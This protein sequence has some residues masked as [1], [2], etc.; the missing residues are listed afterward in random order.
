MAAGA[1]STGTAVAALRE[2][3]MPQRIG[4]GCGRLVA[5]LSASAFLAAA[6]VAATPVWRMA[7]AW[8]ACSS[9]TAW[10]RPQALRWTRA[11][12]GS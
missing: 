11:S 12:S 7:P 8:I 2:Q 10:R 4:R 1:G 3:P 9:T 6:M 5:R